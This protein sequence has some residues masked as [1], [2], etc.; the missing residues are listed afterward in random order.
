MEPN[1]WKNSKDHE[2]EVGKTYQVGLMDV[3]V[4]TYLGGEMWEI[5]EQVR[6]Y[7][8]MWWRPLSDT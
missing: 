4:A 3:A 7:I 6:Q 1:D 2:P 5:G 8:W